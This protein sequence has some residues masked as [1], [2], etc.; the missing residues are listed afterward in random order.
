MEL[1]K[2]RSAGDPDLVRRNK[3]TIDPLLPSII[4]IIM[5]ALATVYLYCS[6]AP[7]KSVISS[8]II[9]IVYCIVAYL[10]NSKPK[11]NKGV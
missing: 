9:V 8:G 2:I 6:A 10:L 1:K 4:A 3:N 11:K 7:I 5:Q